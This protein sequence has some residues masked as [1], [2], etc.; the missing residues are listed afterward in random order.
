MGSAA[1]WP[2][3]AAAVADATPPDRR[4][5]GMGKL[6]MAFLGGLAAGP[7]L[8]LFV[9][10]F[11]GDVRAGFYL[12]SMLLALA[13]LITAT[14]FPP[15]HR[16]TASDPAAGAY[17]ASGRAGQLGAALGIFRVSRVLFWLY[18]IAFIQMFGIGLLVPIAAIYAKQIVG[19]SEHAIGVLFLAVT[20]TVAVA[21]LPAGRLADH[22]GKP[23]LVA[24]GT[25]L[26]AAGM[27]L[28][29]FS[30]QL[31]WLIVAGVLL[32]GS[33]AVMIPSWL[34]LV[35]ELAPEGRLGLAVGASETVQ[36]LG[37]VFGPLLGGLLWDALGP[38][39]PF[40]ASAA[41]LTVGAILAVTVLRQEQ[42]A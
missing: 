41:A 8:G 14:A 3:S 2:S 35:T 29:P 31:E 39:A 20:V 1:L 9:A 19:L 18:L 25:A 23:Y 33:Y 6:N 34:A 30:R 12:A 27:W 37:L 15:D 38:R 5:T 32:G 36:G 40:I 42:P 11:V 4:A 7:S 22:I 13:A 10:G 17:H 26:G 21:T 28:I 24:A 16:H